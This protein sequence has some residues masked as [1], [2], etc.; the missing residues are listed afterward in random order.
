MCKYMKTPSERILRK[1]LSVL[2]EP[3]SIRQVAEECN[4]HWESA[5]KYLEV[6][7]EAGVLEEIVEGKARRFVRKD[8][9]GKDPENFFGLPLDEET[10]R[11]ID[12]IYGA[13]VRAWVRR[14]GVK[15]GRIEVQK[16]LRK[17]DRKLGLN[18]PMGW[19]IY[20]LLCVRPYDPAREYHGKV[21]GEIERAVEQIVSEVEP[22]AYLAMRTQ[23]AEEGKEL[24]IKTLELKRL[25][26]SGSRQDI[27]AKMYEW[28][29][30]LPEMDEESNDLVNE[31]VG[32]VSDIFR[33]VSREELEMLRS[34][35]V[36][37]FEDIWRVI[38][39]FNFQKDMEKFYGKTARKYITPHI[40]MQKFYASES[41]KHLTE[42]APREKL[43]KEESEFIGRIRAAGLQ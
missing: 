42:I 37:T 20:G 31:F 13:I 26:V 12:A 6:L 35:I 14:F 36:S 43:S 39:L 30:Y 40:A 22:G 24:Y 9:A 11:K 1:I 18:L 32:L 38:A 16:V 7:K 21:S 15:P 5:R 10:K 17:V 29:R 34:E 8:I 4:I 19:Y 23:Y 3:K 2:N 41:L 27:E 25:L 33:L 28:L